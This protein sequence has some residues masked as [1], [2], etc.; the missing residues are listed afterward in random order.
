MKDCTCQAAALAKSK[1]GGL[2][3]GHLE[4]LPA[5]EGADIWMDSTSRELGPFVP[6]QGCAGRGTA[7]TAL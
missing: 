5:M 6:G 7:G 3:G 1:E 4:L 2:E